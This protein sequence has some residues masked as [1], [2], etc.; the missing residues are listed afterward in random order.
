MGREHARALHL[1]GA[2]IAVLCDSQFTS[3]ADLA[4]RYPG[5]VALA[6]PGEIEYSSLDAVFVCTPPSA[7]G[8][9]EMAA[10]ESG[11]PIFLEKPIG[12]CTEQCLPVLNAVVEKGVLSSV[13]YMNRYRNS[14]RHARAVLETEEALGIACNWVGSMYRVPW[15]AHRS[16]SGGPF[17][18]QCT[19]LVDLCRFLGGEIIEVSALAR[20]AASNPAF[21]DSVAV[22]VHFLNGTAGTIYYCCRASEKQIGFQVFLKTRPLTFEGWEFRVAGLEEAEQQQDV[23]LREDTAFLRAIVENDSSHILSNFE[24]AIRTQMVMD[25]IQRSLESGR[26][27]RVPI[28]AE[29]PG[30]QVGSA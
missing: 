2:R 11:V 29:V 30:R 26:S 12:L 14:V 24:D 20:R 7:R 28:L 5:S 6:E 10:I 21:D 8:V 9:V 15:W 4:V 1:A 16:Q 13:G 17:N 22:A 19:H 18:E 27:E 23:Y 25:A 3:A